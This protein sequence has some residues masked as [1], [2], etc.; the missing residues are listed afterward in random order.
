MFSLLTLKSR[1]L[2]F[3]ALGVIGIAAALPFAL[4]EDGPWVAVNFEQSSYAVAEGD[5]VTVTVTL[6]VVPDRE[7]VVP[8]TTTEE[9]GATSTDYS[10]VP[11]SLTFASW[12]TEKTFSFT[13]AQDTIDDDGESVSLAFGSL[14]TGV[15][16]GDT[17][18]TDVFI[19][20]DDGVGIVVS[21][22]ALSI[23]EGGSTTYTV[24]LASQP[25]ADVTV[26]LATSSGSD[27]SVNASSLTFTASNW[28]DEQ[29]VTVSAAQDDD[30]L[31]ETAT[32][33]HAVS[34]ADGDYDGIRMASVGVSVID[35][36]DVPVTVT[37][38]QAAHP[39]TEGSAVTV[40]VTL[41]ADPERRVVIPLTKSER[42]GITGADYSGVPETLTFDGG[43]TEET[44][45]VTVVQDMVDDD[46]ESVAIGF[47]SLPNAVTAGATSETAVSIN[48]DDVPSV[49]VTFES[50]AYSVDEGG[51]VEVKITLSADP[52]RQ[53]VVPIATTEQDGASSD[54]YSGVPADVTFESGETEQSFTFTAAQDRIDDDGENDGE[55]VKLAFGASLPNGVREGTTSETTLTIIDDDG[56]GITVSPTTLNMAEGLSK[57]YTVVLA[58]QPAANV[59]VSVTVPSNS[60]VTVDRRAL[61]FT[62]SNWEAVQT[63]TVSS[64]HDFDGTDETVTITHAVTAAA[65]DYSGKAV[66]SV[67]VN[68][69]DND[70]V[71]VKASFERESYRVTEGSTIT[72]K[73]TLDKDPERQ[74]VIPIET[75]EQD[76]MTSADYSG[77]PSSVT[78]E[79]GE[80]EHSF[81]FTAVQDQ[82]DDDEESVKLDFGSL[83]TAVTGGT[84]DE[85]TIT[86]TDDDPTYVARAPDAT[87]SAPVPVPVEVSFERAGYTVVE[88]NSVTVTLTLSADPERQVVVPISVTEE[89]GATSADYSGVPSSVT[90]ESGETSSSFTF[91]ATQDV[92][93]DDDESLRL[94]LGAL[95]NDVTAG[96]IKATNISIIDD[97]G[98]E[99]VRE[100]TVTF[101]QSTYSV[102]EGS[103]VSVKVMLDGD[104][105]RQVVIPIT[106]TWY[107]G[108]T[109]SDY[110]GIPSQV[111]FES[112][113]QE[114]TFDFAATEDMLDD[115]EEAVALGIGLPLP[116]AVILGSRNEAMV[117]IND[118][119]GVG[120]RISPSGLTID[121]GEDDTYTVVLNSQ[122]T[123]DVVVTVGTPTDPDVSADE[124]TLTFTDSTWDD[125]QTVTVSTEQDEDYLDDT[126]TIAHTVASTD[127]DYNGI[128]VRSLNV[129]V[130]DDEEVPV[131][132]NFASATYSV[133]EGDTA[134]IRV[135]LDKDPER[136]VVIPI[137]KS[138][139][140]DAGGDDYSGVPENV[141][142]RSGDTEETII[143]SATQDDIDD[144]GESVTLGFGL[145][146]PDEV[147]AGT[148]NE[149][150]VSINDDDGVGV[151]VSPTA[152]TIGE[153]SSGNYTVVL[154][155]QP[156]AD[157][158][159]TISE[160]GS[161]DVSAD[162]T[163]LTF[164]DS[165][166]DDRQTVTVTAAHDDTDHLDE[167]ATIT[168]AATSTDSAY[169]GISVGSVEVEVIDDEDVPVT[170]T[171][172]RATYLV[173]EGDQV[174]VEITLSEDPERR[175]VV[176]IN[177]TEQDGATSADYSGVPR[178]VTFESGETEQSF[179]FTARQDTVDD[180]DESVKLG[181]GSLPNAVTE[182]TN[183]EATIDI[184]D[185]DNPFVKVNFG[186]TAYSVDEGS[187]VTVTVTLSADPE[188]QVEIPITKSD[189]GGV[190]SPADYSGVPETLTFVSGDTEETFT[191]TAAQDMLDDDGESVRLSFGSDLPSRI[192]GGTIPQT[193]VSINDDDGA[194]VTIEPP[195]LTI[196]EGFTDT[197]TVVLTSQPTADV[198]VTVN[199]PSG[200]DISVDATT[201]LTFT[202]TDWHQ[203]QTVTVTADQDD[204]HLDDTGTITHTVAS[205]DADYNN[206]AAGSVKVTTT[207]DEDVPVTV[208]FE[209]AG[210]TVDEGGTVTVKV[211]LSEDPERYVVIPLVKTDQDGATS[212]DY[213]S[214][215]TAVSFFSG[216]TEHTFSFATVQ[217]TV[218]DDG[219]SV[220][221]VL[222][223]SS[224]DR[225]SDG[226]TVETTVSITDDDVPPVDVSFEFD[227]YSVDEGDDLT[228]KVKLSADPE[229]QVIIPITKAKQDGASDADFTVP[230][231]VTFESGETEKTFTFTAT[232]D[233][234]DDDDESVKLGFNTNSLHRVSDGTPTE[235][236]VSI[237]DDDDPPVTVYFEQATY[238][239]A[240]SDDTSTN[241]VAEN[242]VTVTV[243]LSADPERQVIIPITK[244]KQGGVGDGDFTVPADV[245]FES[246]EV[247]KT[248]T[249][250]AIHDTVDDDDESVKLV[251]D[252]SSLDRVSAGT[253]GETT[254]S[255]DDDDAPSVQVSFEQATYTVA[256]SDDT[257]T[258]G[259]TEN[260][261]TVTVKLSA[262]PERQVIISITASEQ[263]G[264]N[265]TDYSGA[266]V[267]VT[268]ESGETEQ[269]FTFTAEHD[270]VDDD[271][272]SVLLRF[273]TGAFPDRVSEGTTNAA[274]VRIDDDDDPFVE[275]SF[276]LSSY[277]VNEGDTVE[278]KVKLSADPE[279]QLIIPLVTTNQDDASSSDYTPMPNNVTFQPTETEVIV[280]FIATDD[281]LDDDGESVKLSFGAQLPDRVTATTPDETTIDIND[282]EGASVKVSQTSLTINEGSSETYTVVLTSQ[283]TDDVV[284][285]ITKSGSSDIS[286]DETTLTFTDSNWE[287]EQT[288]TVTGDQDDD[289]LAERATITHSAASTDTDYG[290]ISVGSVNITV[291]DDETEVSFSS[292]MYMA[293]EGGEDATVVVQ[294]SQP[295]P[296]RMVIQITAEGK[297]GATPDDWT[298]APTTLTFNAGEDEKSFTVV[299]FDDN[300]EDSGEQVE[301]GFGTP[302][303]TGVV[304][305]DPDTAIVILANAECD[306]LATKMI[307][308]DEI[309]E[310]T[311]AGEKDFWTFD[312]DPYRHYIIEVIGADDGRDMLDEDTHPGDLTLADP[313]LISVRMVNGTEGAEYS[314]HIDDAGYGRNSLGTWIWLGPGPWQIEVD[315]KGGTGTYQ[316][317][318]RV[319]TICMMVDG[320]KAY[321][322]FGGPNGY[323]EELDLPADTTA[324]HSV[325]PARGLSR[326]SFG[327]GGFLGDIWSDE[328]D[329]DW[330][331]TE[332][333]QG[334]EYTIDLWS[335]DYAPTKHQATDLKILGIYDSNGTVIA[336]TASSGSGAHVSV[337]FEPD[338]TGVYYIAVGSGAADRTGMYIIRVGY[339]S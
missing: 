302:L 252:T 272:E 327:S 198:T 290:G 97:D 214:L 136:E 154:N 101:E 155:S 260:E 279:R 14:P 308:L 179:T 281:S 190:S 33:G 185:D 60:D 284:I 176:P 105:G 313:N 170:V 7:V 131:T 71:R 187:T 72:V 75:T 32:I 122:P 100:V 244:T 119:D 161:S 17:D 227:A 267:D 319:N 275:V 3:A 317:K 257:S 47:G 129:K 109:P 67:T 89:G 55:S 296:A 142:F 286:V 263:G 181:F 229:R 250:T 233:T 297:A 238:T 291:I 118:N 12:E 137:T 213:L 23:V 223:T 266:P 333:T 19:N 207:D 303:P 46:D 193:T 242:E 1:V 231:D 241:N 293:T 274:T 254:V 280:D 41:S 320:E 92:A 152:L 228:V 205:T 37:F 76:G 108:I 322:W 235:A 127:A 51:E 163:T 203:E 69:I 22:S 29:T 59:T 16:E 209:E 218:D 162:E 270:E 63:V 116:D 79:S 114:K 168:H 232:Q 80:T 225:V 21:E 315:G 38:D 339:E 310:I 123:D 206:F 324:T 258:N 221:L 201:P 277:S 172:E 256:E 202:D 158:V 335:D 66:A 300:V 98:P 331:K 189:Q 177:K 318:I 164:T 289:A 151:I 337:V 140:G 24:V 13:A 306:N 26:A 143:F 35:D 87:P 239:V 138:E 134:R 245:T 68:V 196:D 211:T 132:V 112:G 330:F 77:V 146:L 220:K 251:L 50:A 61:T 247:E 84:T 31:D 184:N 278:V 125:P 264:A 159:I 305:G 39:V 311:Q 95:P 292:D 167:S 111:I 128:R 268:F 113:E 130:V 78:F 106:Q 217:D 276:E 150:T 199:V 48:D 120:V 126:A 86:I 30:H 200:P 259:I 316:I 99:P 208:S 194:G 204:D 294:L 323:A 173:D 212:D 283:P 255:I 171:F 36:E 219:E 82:A 94:D 243:K 309:G 165:D 236:T 234:V 2:G 85:T 42:G 15:N 295:A 103:R 45:T 121:E 215:P 64:V 104:P 175:V 298:G 287:D 285:T 334:V 186:Q 269:T 5:S 312:F 57:T 222:D 93:D 52:E 6:D 230:A 246:G 90:F 273:D 174:T 11:A 226:T 73:V 70:D 224:L 282:D 34:S 54:D 166:W 248:I 135:T 307:V 336:N 153:G 62:A 261:V 191:F 183:N 133:N 169:N 271:N 25:T 96:T 301:L 178:N 83:P 49:T 88:G 117:T 40:T 332:L 44:F 145:T 74:V 192:S 10:G 326:D 124:T 197:Y 18:E 240:E 9:G 160:T 56:T 107:G 237:D 328:P 253:P 304:L 139:Q 20:D 249:F 325:R 210:Y 288:V 147:T 299:A 148:T 182:G 27:V 81:T 115:D 102:D 156:T 216:E 141:T 180:D 91:T 110:S 149:A 314:W 265:P 157:V 8:I 58:S 53:V 144:D 195:S 188:R 43:E 338:S 321:P 65:S 4:S 262:D 329:E 28:D